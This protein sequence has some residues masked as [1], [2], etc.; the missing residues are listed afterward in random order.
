MVPLKSSL[1]KDNFAGFLQPALSFQHEQI[2]VKTARCDRLIET[3]E[4][5]VKNGWKMRFPFG[6]AYSSGGKL[7]VSGRTWILKHHLAILDPRAAHRSGQ[8]DDYNLRCP[9]FWSICT[10]LFLSILLQKGK[11]HVDPKMPKITTN[12]DLESVMF[13]GRLAG[14]TDLDSHMGQPQHQKLW[15]AS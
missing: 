4:V 1:G 7:L 5:F 13:G 9:G 11:L 15:M 6:M 12:C 10:C 3:N 14:M 2:A 8:A